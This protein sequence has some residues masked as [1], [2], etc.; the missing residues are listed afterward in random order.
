MHLETLWN[1]LR[2]QV[3]FTLHC[4]YG[5]TARDDRAGLE[6]LCRLHGARIDTDQD[7]VIS[8]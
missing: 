3:P 2:A 5:L 8:A 7:A 1:E 6:A 4:G